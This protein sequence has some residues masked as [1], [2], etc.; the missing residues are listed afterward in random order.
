M[1]DPVTESIIDKFYDFHTE[2]KTSTSINVIT[3]STNISKLN[4]E[5]RVYPLD[6]IYIHTNS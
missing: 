3:T 5:E 6:R 1:K 2:Y 4:P